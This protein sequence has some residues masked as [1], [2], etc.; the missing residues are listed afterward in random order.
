MDVLNLALVGAFVSVL[1][2]FVKS[3]FVTSRIGTVG[4]VIGLSIA[5]GALFWFFNDTK[6]WQAS[7]QV[8][9]YANAFYGFVIKQ[10]DS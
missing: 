5:A 3:S 9:L 8:L 10:I 2:Q 4:A 7:L 6:F 1:V